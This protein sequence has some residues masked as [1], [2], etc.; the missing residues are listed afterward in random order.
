MAQM[1]RFFTWNA[2]SHG[3]FFRQSTRPR[4]LPLSPARRTCG[5][6]SF[7]KAV[8]NRR[9]PADDSCKKSDPVTSYGGII[10]IRLKGRSW[11][12]PSQPANTSSPVFNCPSYSALVRKIQASVF[13][14]KPPSDGRILLPLKH[15]CNMRFVDNVDSAR[16]RASFCLRL[17]TSSPQPDKIDLSVTQHRLRWIL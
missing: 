7:L 17:F 3:F 13:A 2:P 1:M 4:A 11:S 9:R 12:T 10:R 14:R 6:F 8:K 16:S 5:R 15:I